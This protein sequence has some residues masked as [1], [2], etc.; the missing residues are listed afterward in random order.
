MVTLVGERNLCGNFEPAW[1]NVEFA[2]CTA[3]FQL[4]TWDLLSGEFW[5][6]SG[7]HQWDDKQ[8]SVFH[9]GFPSLFW[10]SCGKECVGHCFHWSW[11]AGGGQGCTGGRFLVVFESWWILESLNKRDPELTFPSSHWAAGEELCAE[12]MCWIVCG[13]LFAVYETKGFALD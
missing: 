6:S 10:S 11:G 12:L 9:W 8:C 7:A 5:G 13:C 2:E 4:L 3:A 1:L